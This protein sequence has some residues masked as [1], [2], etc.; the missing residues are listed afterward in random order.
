MKIVSQCR[1]QARRVYYGAFFEAK[2][3]IPAN[4]PLL[5]SPGKRTLALGFLLAI[6]TIA[7]YYPVNKLPFTAY[8]DQLY[9]YENAHVTMG[10]SWDTI[11]WAL[12]SFDA[13]NW[14]PL[15]WL[16]HALDCQLFILDPGRHHDVNLLWHVLNVLLLFHVLRRATGY[17]GRSAMVA[18]LFA[19]HPVNVESVAWIAERKNLLSVFF[20]LLALGA[21][22]WYASGPRVGR[23]L[24]VALLYGLG[25]MSKPQV[26]TFPFVLLLWDY[27]PLHRMFAGIEGSSFAGAGTPVV[28][29]R[30]F[31][32]LILEKLPLIVLAAADAVITMA[33]QFRAGTETWYPISVGVKNAIL[34][35]LRYIEKALFP[36]KLAVLYPHPEFSIRASQVL[37]SF[38]ALLAITALVA[39]C[40]RRRYLTVG[41]LWFLGTL[42]PMIGLVQVGVQGMADRYAYLPYIGLFIMICWGAAD[43][44]SKAK[45]SGTS[46]G[47]WKWLEGYGIS[48]QAGVGI[49]VLVVLAVVTRR[50][51]TFWSDDLT[52]WSH[53]LQVT[54]RNWSA[55]DNLGNELSK[56]ERT[57]EALS[58]YFNAAEIRPTDPVSNLNIG[59]YEAQ[60]GDL[61][62]AIERFKRVVSL[63]SSAKPELKAKAFNNMGHAYADLGDYEHAGQSFAAAVRKDP[64][65]FGAWIGLG[66][67][68][69]KSGK[70]DLAVKAYSRAMKI[71]PQDWGYLLLARALE[72]SGRKDE[73]QAANQQAKS[74]SLDLDEARRAADEML[75]H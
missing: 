34:S 67:M 62:G 17:I 2:K 6:A 56:Q 18:A 71:Q 53:A 65:Y 59:A 36:S 7:V 64:G 9:V 33:A 73:A 35:Y 22:R 48:G 24:V 39:V 32:W 19:L 72:Q 14:H 54:S 63:G 5:S 20:F 8:D 60:G 1:E 75:R 49:A 47:P 26:V 13:D 28:P 51:I 52:L 25:L 23:Y 31:S 38:A 30:S 57:Q 27:W 37:V 29:P 50:Q 66:V 10:L 70:L 41:W 21:Y 44:L 58:H 15:T 40:R 55:E 74:L 11:R 16:S 12:T 46:R 42:V 3:E 4:R 61:A 45:K 43:L 68:A 69:Q